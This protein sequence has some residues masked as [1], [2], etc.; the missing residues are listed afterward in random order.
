MRSVFAIVHQAD[1]EL[2]DMLGLVPLRVA[3]SLQ[4]S[5]ASTNP[6]FRGRHKKVP[7]NTE[8]NWNKQFIK[9]PTGHSHRCLL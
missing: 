7:D 1:S 8:G 3:Q 4:Q 6:T 9:H 2:H 5:V